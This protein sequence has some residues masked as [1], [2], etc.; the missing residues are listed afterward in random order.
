MRKRR[1]SRRQEV[2]GEGALPR[3][4]YAVTPRDTL[5]TKKYG[6]AETFRVRKI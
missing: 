5:S 1:Q 4:S 3:H 6:V 2:R